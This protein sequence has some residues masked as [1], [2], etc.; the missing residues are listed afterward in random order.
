MKGNREAGESWK[1]KR[2]DAAKRKQE[3]EERWEK[4]PAKDITMYRK[5]KLRERR[6]RRNGRGN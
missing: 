1:T 4:V 2:G 6:E 3:Q 5:G